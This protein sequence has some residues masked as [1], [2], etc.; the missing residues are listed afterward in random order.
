[1]AGSR[2][3][4]R[5]ASIAT[6]ATLAAPRAV[7]ARSAADSMAL[8]PSADQQAAVALR[9]LRTLAPTLHQHPDLLAEVRHTLRMAEAR[10]I[11]LA[12]GNAHTGIGI[13]ALDTFAAG[14]VGSPTGSTPLSSSP[15]G[16][17]GGWA[18]TKDQPKGVMNARILRNF[19][20]DPWVFAAKKHRAEAIAR[21]DVD[22][23]PLDPDK[24]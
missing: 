23:L 14:T 6:P 20:N 16:Q 22:V 12:T 8:V 9:S 3:N 7:S 19:A 18:G 24:P 10:H 5:R 4:R 11:A 15:S 1:M 2:N 13:P 17:L 21:A